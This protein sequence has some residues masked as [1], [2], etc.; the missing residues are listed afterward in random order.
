MNRTEFGRA[1]AMLSAS[2]GKPMPTEQVEAWHLL[3]GDLTRDE[4]QAGIVGALSAHTYGGLP[5][6][7][8]IRQHAKPELRV[9]ACDVD[10]AAVS[11]WTGVVNAMRTHGGYA[12]VDFSPLVNAVVRALGGWV[13]LT[14]QPSEDLLRYVRP[15]FLQTFKA[16]AAA[17]VR[18]N[19][20]APLPGIEDL[21]RA[22]KGLPVDPPKVIDLRL[23][24][25]TAR[26]LPALA[27][28]QRE[29]RLAHQA[30][31][32][33]AMPDTMARELAAIGGGT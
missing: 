18:Q 30:G 1:M 31:D 21:D 29:R 33:Q 12:T 24:G 26:V 5:P 16:L 7:G 32:D 9:L 6:V 15:Q 17:G 22:R 19:E 2:V 10:T 28:P 4:L 27:G 23:P 14:E 11:A 8:L 20:S 25:P 3:L 13:R